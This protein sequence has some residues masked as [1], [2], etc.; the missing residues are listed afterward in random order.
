MA[1]QIFLLI[2]L[3]CK[4]FL[5]VIVSS[6]GQCWSNQLPYLPCCTESVLCQV[7]MACDSGRCF[8]FFSEICYLR[9][10]WRRK[11][12]ELRLFTIGSV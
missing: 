12:A 3:S 10:K 7:G 9:N 1:S 4:R 2:Y 5:W 11:I 8:I 6:N